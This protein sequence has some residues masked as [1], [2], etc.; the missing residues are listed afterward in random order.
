[1]TEIKPISKVDPGELL[2]ETARNAQH[3]TPE[4]QRVIAR[5]MDLQTAPVMVVKPTEIDLPGMPYAIGR[6]KK[7]QK[8][9][10]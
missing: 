7:G 1:M 3:I 9:Q 6:K 2:L 4:V 8:V 10:L 5:F